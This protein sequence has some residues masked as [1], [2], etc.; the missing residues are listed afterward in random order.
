ML[1][2]DD[3]DEVR[4]VLLHALDQDG[5]PCRVRA[6]RDGEEL[7]GNLLRWQRK[8]AGAP[9]LI[10]LDLYMPRRNGHETLRA[11]RAHPSLVGVPVVVLSSSEA[12]EDAATAYRLGANQFAIKPSSMSDF[13]SLV[14]HLLHRWLEKPPSPAAS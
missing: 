12:P 6:F 13:R 1:I 11:I 9:A 2:A 3:D 10:L 7:W 4:M 14:Q 5:T 8:G